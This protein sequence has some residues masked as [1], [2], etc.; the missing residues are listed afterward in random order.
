M[1]PTH[2][3]KDTDMVGGWMYTGGGRSQGGCTHGQRWNK[4]FSFCEPVFQL[5]KFSVKQ[6][7]FQPNLPCK[8]ALM[9]VI[10]RQTKSN[11][12]SI[13]LSWLRSISKIGLP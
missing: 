1:I 8:I 6:R 13:D 9:I 5:P 12:A 7:D 10:S 4:Y 11:S 2:L 3:T